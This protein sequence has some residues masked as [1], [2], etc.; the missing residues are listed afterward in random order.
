MSKPHRLGESN[1]VPRATCFNCGKPLDRAAGLDTDNQ[2][3]PGDVTICLD[4]GH[5][6][7]F[8]DQ[9]ALRQLSPEEQIALA[10]NEDV[11]FAQH[12]RAQAF[13]KRKN[14]EQP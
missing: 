7:I 12:M 14:K 4:C 5:L 8:D 10:S 11:L 9:L 2:P 13:A 3:G 6:M 1:I